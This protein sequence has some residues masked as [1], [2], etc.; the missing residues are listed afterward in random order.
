MQ[1][2]IFI[3]QRLSYCLH[4]FRNLMKPFLVVCG[5]GY[6]IE[7]TG[8]YAATTSDA[9]IMKCILNNHSGPPEEAPILWLLEE[10][11]VFVLN[12]GFRDSIP[13]L[14]TCGFEAHIPPTK[15]RAENQLTTDD[16][17]KSR[18]IT[19]IRWVIEGINGRFKRDFRILR[20][21]YFNKSVKNAMLDFRIAAALI[22]DT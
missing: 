7:V 9:T 20:S 4:K 3:F 16:A 10:G 8:P 19:I 14:R 12:R 1:L 15:N 18:R 6:I 21:T 2:Q 5:D 17:N 11:D 13:E 22:N